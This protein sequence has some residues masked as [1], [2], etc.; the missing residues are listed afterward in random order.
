MQGMMRL[1]D[2]GRSLL[3]GLLKKRG[4]LVGVLLCVSFR[5]WAVEDAPAHAREPFRLIML[6][7]TQEYAN[8]GVERIGWPWK[9]T[10][11]PIFYRQTEW[12]ATNKEHL[13]IRMV[14]HV[15]DI[16]ESDFPAEREVADRVSRALRAFG[17]TSRID[18]GTSGDRVF[19]VLGD[20]QRYENGGNGWLQVLTFYPD[21]N[22]IDV[23]T[24]SPWLD[25]Y[26]SEPESE[27]SF[28][29]DMGEKTPSAKWNAGVR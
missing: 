5:L 13:N 6:P 16:V 2:I 7:D 3:S 26:R 14:A 29:Y 4:V 10:R 20:Y 22:R 9:D 24:Y 18:I 23:K 21:E 19:Q 8:A 15:G 28:D 25:E 11:S 27:C 1:D 12:I 17:E